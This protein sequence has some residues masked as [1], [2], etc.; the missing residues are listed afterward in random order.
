MLYT[1]ICVIEMDSGLSSIKASHFLLA[2]KDCMQITILYQEVEL[3]SI[4]NFSILG[5]L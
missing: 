2:F 4:F 1:R 3:H 5:E